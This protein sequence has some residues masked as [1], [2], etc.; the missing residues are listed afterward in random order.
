M[1]NFGIRYDALYK[2]C[3]QLATN[4]R[5]TIVRFGSVVVKDGK[6]IGRGWNV[7]AN[8][9]KLGKLPIVM[10]YANHA[11]VSAM[12]DALNNGYSLE[13]ADVYVAGYFPN[14]NSL[15]IPR[16]AYFTC[17]RCPTYFDRYKIN[18]VSVPL[19]QRWSRLDVSE[20]KESAK[21][22]MGRS[23]ERRIAVG[24]THF[25]LDDVLSA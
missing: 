4:S 21:T 13:G 18:S 23:Q 3:M 2:E 5:S 1:K 24:K 9:K 11:E 14:D 6:I 20:A 8:Q 17:T 25:S 16:D 22:F 12:N 19:Y 15:Y 7:F 10:G